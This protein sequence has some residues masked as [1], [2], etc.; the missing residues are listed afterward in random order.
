MCGQ[1][2][3]REPDS[4][5]TPETGTDPGSFRPSSQA[6]SSAERR[7]SAVGTVPTTLLA[8][9]SADRPPKWGFFSGLLGYTDPSEP[10]CKNHRAFFF[11]ETMEAYRNAMVA[12][13]DAAKKVWATEFGWPT[14]TN[15]PPG[16]VYARDNTPEEQAEYI[17]R[18]YQMGANWGW[19]GG[20]FL[21]NLDWGLVAPGSEL[22]LFSL[23]PPGPAY[24][25]VAAMAKSGEDYT[26]IVA[27]RMTDGAGNGISDVVISD[28]AG[29]NANSSSSGYYTLV[30]LVGGTYTTV[31]ANL[32]F[33]G[34]Q[35]SMGLYD[36]PL[37]GGNRRGRH[38]HHNRVCGL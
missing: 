14:S 2:Q 11:R 3:K 35:A 31:I 25:A 5:K 7:Q 26:N 36:S 20:M 12:A 22:A 23:L 9:Q 27:G 38:L 34:F 19:V 18:A 29:H 1:R 30:G 32:S 6:R 37:S 21:W 10:T 13:G 4:P 28:N 17:V 24:Y 8:C 33:G 16:Y 15:P